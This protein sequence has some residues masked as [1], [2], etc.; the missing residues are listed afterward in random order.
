MFCQGKEILLRPA[1]QK[2][3][4]FWTPAQYSKDSGEEKIIMQAL[5]GGERKFENYLFACTYFTC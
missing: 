4:Q 2:G 3:R 5:T 1:A